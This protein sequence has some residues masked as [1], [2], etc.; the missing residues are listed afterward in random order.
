MSYY[1]DRPQDSYSRDPYDQPQSYGGRPQVPYPWEAEWDERD[2]RW[3]FVNRETGERTFQHP[4]PSYGGCG[5]DESGSGQGY[6]GADDRRRYEQE[7]EK[8]SHTGRNIALGA[9]A[10]LLGGALL[11]HE[12]EKVEDK[13]D[14]AKNDVENDFRDGVQ[15]V[16]NFPDN[17]ARWTGEKVQEVEDIPQDIDRKWDNAVQDVEDVPEDVAGW[18]GR[19]VGD[20]ERFGDDVDNA[21][22][23]G[24]DDA[25]YDDNY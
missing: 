6:G 22:D 5:Y 12:G 25:R 23:Q 17:A 1:N 10:G 8:K 19:K 2:G 20:V 16:E 21:Y 4:Q 15:D 9:A 7:S 3:F 14:D 18:A 24:R 11:M 13:W